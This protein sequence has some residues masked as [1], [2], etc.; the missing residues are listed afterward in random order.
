MP[1]NRREF[2]KLTGL[3]L[4]GALVSTDAAHASGG[5][6]DAGEHTALLYDATM[7]VGCHACSNACRDW[8]NTDPERDP[9]GLY[10]APRNLSFDT[11][12]IIQLYQNDQEHSFVK[13]Q[14]M[15]CIE[16]ACASACPVHALIKQDTG[17]VTWDAGRCIGC[18]YCM[19][20]CPFHI[21]RFEWDVPIGEIAKCTL[22]QG[23]L[24]DG[25]GPNCA[26]WCPTGALISG[27]RDE[28]VAE[29]EGRLAENPGRYV[30]H[31][32]GKDDAGGT[33]VLYLSAVPFVKLGFPE[34]GSE[35][36]PEVS[37]TVGNI[38]IPGIVIGGP[39]LLAGIHYLSKGGE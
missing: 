39:L 29:A 25:K 24:L 13:H 35:P 33:S 8:N 19:L 27:K 5:A 30:D 1:I 2:I 37:E 18:R 28:L 32:Y 6:S 20:A 3:G 10:D 4:S 16:P 31:I 14:C 21:P 22:C 36:V 11:W 12:T 9:S 26:E 38:I 17:A 34:L 7:C 15:H 23:R